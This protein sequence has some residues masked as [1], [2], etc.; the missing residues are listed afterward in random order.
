MASDLRAA[1]PQTPARELVTASGVEPLRQVAVTSP[2]LSLYMALFRPWFSCGGGW[3]T[4][5]CLGDGA[6]SQSEWIGPCR[7]SQ[8]SRSVLR[9]RHRADDAARIGDCLHHCAD[10]RAGRT[11][12]HRLGSVPAAIRSRSLANHR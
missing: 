8:V 3:V 7:A 9:G 10:R 4:P 12:F 1:G 11:V 5:D 6:Q 2:L